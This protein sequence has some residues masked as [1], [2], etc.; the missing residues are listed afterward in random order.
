MSRK[1]YVNDPLG[2]V[3]A[4]DRYFIADSIFSDPKAYQIAKYLV[5]L[6]PKECA[7]VSPTCS[8]MISGAKSQSARDAFA[9]LC[10]SNVIKKKDSV[11]LS[12][13]VSFEE[14]TKKIVSTYL[15]HGK[16]IKI[17]L[18]TQDENEGY[19]FEKMDYEDNHLNDIDAIGF[20]EN[21]KCIKYVYEAPKEEFSFKFV[22]QGQAVSSL[23]VIF[24]KTTG[25]QKKIISDPNNPSSTCA[26]RENKGYHL[27]AY[28]TYK[29]ILFEADKFQLIG[30]INGQDI[31]SDLYDFYFGQEQRWV[32]T[33]ENQKLVCTFF[34]GSGNAVPKQQP[35]Q[36]VTPKDDG[37]GEAS[38]S[39][40]GHLY[41]RD[42][43]PAN[44]V[45]T[46]AFFGRTVDPSIKSS[47][48]LIPVAN[49][50]KEGDTIYYANKKALTLVK[51]LGDGGEGIVYTTNEKGVVAKIYHKNKLTVLRR[52][53]IEKMTSLKLGEKNPNIIWPLN[54]LYLD[55][56]NNAPFV[57]FTMRSVAGGISLYTFCSQRPDRK[58]PELGVLDVSRTQLAEL[59]IS[60]V[61][62]VAYLHARNILIRDLKLQNLMIVP[63]EP[64]KC[65]LVDCDSYQIGEY[66]APVHT[67]D[68]IPPEAFGLN[69][70]EVYQNKYS[71]SFTLFITLFRLLVTKDAIIYSTVGSDKSGLDLCREG[72]FP[73][74]MNRASTDAKVKG[75]PQ[76]AWSHFPSYMKEA[77]ISVAD[78]SGKRYEK[79]K[80]IMADEWLK[81]LLA[82]HK[83]LK[84]G[85]KG[86]LG[87]KD[88]GFDVTYSL[89]TI[90]YH[91][92]DL[93]LI[94]T[95]KGEKSDFSLSRLVKNILKE[96]HLN[97]NENE[98][99]DSLKKNGSYKKEGQLAI[100]ITKDVGILCTAKYAYNSI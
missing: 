74:S 58:R 17:L 55:T 21:V 32:V 93:K 12:M 30:Q 70:G 94:S 38:G 56:S 84:A 28:K 20:D 37:L 72:A 76:S 11:P 69:A 75:Y 15:E 77:A 46:D 29:D 80:R 36:P 35:Q 90:D 1:E 78:K 14:A 25:V 51:K 13:P 42:P 89:N 24:H 7:Y 34:I 91:L 62:T 45:M 86:R 98:I 22:F 26:Y 6:L 52:K 88:P 95:V 16:S 99:I 81:L 4:Y 92:V 44:E 100:L 50:P 23:K 85:T 53:K 79:T 67:D 97:I 33:I 54:S 40:T 96:S 47:D 10:N 3:K 18:I 64:T 19:N 66:V 61:D 48:C 60:L 5:Q 82:Y 63:N 65:L 83:D 68:Y 9:L 8:K 31:K 59:V 73:F 43:V 49:V 41:S 71:D 87:S 2:I 39:Y 27:F 57:G